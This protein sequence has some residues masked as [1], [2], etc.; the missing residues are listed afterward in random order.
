[1][2]ATT[3]FCKHRRIAD[4]DRA[5][6]RLHAGP[7]LRR[8]S[9][10]DCQLVFD[11]DDTLNSN[12][13][14][15]SEASDKLAVIYARLCPHGRDP[16][17]LRKLH[18]DYDNALIPTLGYTP[19]RWYTSAHEFARQVAGRPLT[20]SESREVDAAADHA[21]GVG[22]ILPGVERA[23]DALTRA[24]VPMLLKTKG[25]RDKQTEK[26]AAHRFDRFF[27]DAIVIVDRKD[28]QTFRDVPAA[29][30]FTNVVSIGDSERSDVLPALAVGHRAVH[31]DKGADA[32]DYE[33]PGAD[34]G[35]PRVPS[36]PHAVLHLAAAGSGAARPALALS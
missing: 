29:Y 14:L 2:S 23:L 26:L 34:H 20:A 32:W 13:V 16:Q 17:T 3:V 5:A 18:A 36:M 15:F 30:G 24:G 9:S 6:D 22:T 8:L 35:A 11:M 31:I 21:M 1:M 19:H 33:A 12:Q 25:D 7:M 4:P 28:E 10:L 27:G